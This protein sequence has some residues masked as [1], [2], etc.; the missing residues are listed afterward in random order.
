MKDYNYEVALSFAGEDRDYVEQVANDLKNSGVR[1]FYD[2]HVTAELW[3][4][5]LY[6][7]LYDVYKNQAKYTIIFVSKCYLEKL[8]TNHERV[9]AQARAFTE[10]EEY[11]LPARFDNSEIPGIS[12]TTGYIDL[13]IT[14][15]SELV[16]LIIDKLKFTKINSNDQVLRRSVRLSNIITKA[17]VLV[18]NDHINTMSQT[19]SYLSNA[20]IYVDTAENTDDAIEKLT[21][22]HYD[23]VVSDIRRGDIADEGLRFLKETRRLGIARPTIF[24]VYNLDPERGVPP[25]AFGISRYVDEIVHLVFDAIERERG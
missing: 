12:N 16:Q 6:T 19:I 5:N 10:N 11:I 20:G 22:Q 8:W 14:S 4:K 1:V 9:S 3:G 7:H 15:P 23:V 18:V 21:N 17:A 24:S 13:K 25:Y 2:K